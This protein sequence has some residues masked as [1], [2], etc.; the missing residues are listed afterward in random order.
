MWNVL[1]CG[2]GELTHRLA[3]HLPGSAVVGIDTSPPADVHLSRAV[4]GHREAIGPF[5]YRLPGDRAAVQAGC[6]WCAGQR[7]I[8]HPFHLAGALQA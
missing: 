4:E 2:T 1:G 8:D 7:Q 3:G 6:L 5:L